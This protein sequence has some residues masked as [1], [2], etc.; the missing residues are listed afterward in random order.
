MVLR[1]RPDRGVGKG[2]RTSERES[3]HSRDSRTDQRRSSDRSES[4]DKGHDDS[5]DRDSGDEGPAGRSFGSRGGDSP[6]NDDHFTGAPGYAAAVP[7]LK[8][9]PGYDARYATAYAGYPICP[10]IYQLSCFQDRVYSLQDTL[11]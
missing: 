5:M 8:Q 3:G 1:R 2:D 6:T 9:Q 11:I 7:Y 4:R 10:P